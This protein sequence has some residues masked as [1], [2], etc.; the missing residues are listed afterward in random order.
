MRNE[1]DRI[2]NKGNL[3]LKQQINKIIKLNC[4]KIH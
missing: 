3:P 2:Q 4:K 1:N